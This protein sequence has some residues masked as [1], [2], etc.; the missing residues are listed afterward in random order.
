MSSSNPT[1]AA[2]RAEHAALRDRVRRVLAASHGGNYAPP[3]LPPALRRTRSGRRPAAR[4]RRRSTRRSRR[5]TR[6][7]SGRGRS[8][9]RRR[10]RR[11]RRC[12]ALLLSLLAGVSG[13]LILPLSFD[14]LLWKA[15]EASPELSRLDAPLNPLNVDRAFRELEGIMQ[16]V[17]RVQQG[18]LVALDV[19]RISDFRQKLTGGGGRP[20]RRAAGRGRLARRRP[21]PPRPRARS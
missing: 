3:P 15:C 12:S 17:L 20:R 13:A 6:A 7:I 18:Q 8:R 1:L 2:I 11:T 5:G 19:G 9:R 4:R 10:R 14:A 21:P 16:G